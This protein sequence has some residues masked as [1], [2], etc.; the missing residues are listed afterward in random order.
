MRTRISAI[1]ISNIEGKQI[2][3][4]ES[5]QRT[6]ADY[7]GDNVFG[8]KVMRNY[9][10][11]KAYKSLSEAIK[12][13]GPLDPSI[14][15]EVAEA[16]KNWA[17]S[18]G[19]THYTHWFQPLTGLTAEKHDSFIELDG[20]GG[21]IL[22][23]SGN[24]LIQGEPDASSF[25]SGGLRPTFEARGYTGWDPTS[26]AFV[27]EGARGATLCIPTY[28]V[29]WN[30]EA[31][32][33][34]TPLLRSM[35][36]ISRQVAR[37]AKVLGIKITQNA[38]STL[39]GE[40]EYFLIDR[41][42]Y[43]QRI[44]LIQTGRTLFGKEPAK[45]QQMA[46]HYFGAIKDRVIGFMED[47]D[48]EM[49]KLGTP[50]K[51]R[52]NEVA[53][54]QYEVAPIFE[55]QNLAVDHNMLTMEVM[56]KVAKRHGLVCLLHEKPFAGINGSGKHCNWSVTGPDGK[57]WLSPGD[58]PHENE[59][60]LI[61]LCAVIKAV[62]EHA[63]FLR[64][65]VA[66]A[67]NDHRLGSHEAPPAIISIYLGEQLND[68]IEQIE[69]GSGVKSSKKG[70]T[71]AVGVDSLPGLPRHASDRNRTSP[72]AFTGSKFEF[73]AVGS[74]ASLAGPNVV[75][76]TIAAGAL[77]EICTKLE[78][79]KK[80][81]KN[82]NKTVQKLLQDIIKK[83]KRVIFNGDNYTEAWVKEAKR[84]GLPNLKTTPEA[85]KVTKDPAVVS[86]CEKQGVLTKTEL[87]SRYEV[88]METYETI[89]RYEA[90]LA[91][92][93]AK[94]TIIPVAMDYQIE[95][96]ETIKTVESINK[97]KS[98][99]SRKLLKDVSKETEKA[100]TAVS[101][102]EAALKGDSIQ[103]MKTSTEA[104]REIVDILEGLVPADS[105]PLPSYAEML[106]IT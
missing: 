100:I 41:D 72:F 10:S 48:R 4:T 59:R 88:Y 22:E 29:G 6:V 39:G 85:L 3:T 37:L 25:P 93:M 63:A 27:K 26:P 9:L 76:N 98:T 11:E 61:M 18:K 105:W 7:Y 32:D 44:D 90:G 99:A 84:R 103:K 38:F 16:M 36:A 56:Q 91:A 5:G 52:H 65:S 74:A 53:P 14:A 67:G 8:L 35:K 102:L 58:N 50:L 75:I 64:A 66:S 79:A 96:A 97:I 15:D 12:N 51:T 54:G 73:R 92:D 55:N 21:V 62:D 60:F 17:V 43:H 87:F 89:I 1:D 30:G 81:N 28:F 101:N 94:T 33:K 95:L 104:L 86:L 46:D 45:H 47:L 34:K 23:F 57:N 31:L 77:D 42:F 78:T 2:M 80:S 24:A 82:M 106:F 13:S 20:E 19:A 83:H 71:L 70:G 49:W 40:Q 68:I 69:K